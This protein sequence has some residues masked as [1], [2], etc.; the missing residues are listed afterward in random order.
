A[1]RRRPGPLH[2]DPG[3]RAGGSAL[4]ICHCWRAPMLER[5]AKAE[6]LAERQRKL[7]EERLA[8]Q[9]G[10]QGRKAVTR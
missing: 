8:Q 3:R 2:P 9:R 4:A 6:A 10:A 7:Y 5:M 1:R